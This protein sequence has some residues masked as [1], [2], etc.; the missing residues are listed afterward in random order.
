MVWYRVSCVSDIA[1]YFIC[2]GLMRKRCQLINVDLDVEGF[3]SPSGTLPPKNIHCT[4]PPPTYANPYLNAGSSGSSETGKC[5]ITGG[6]LFM[7]VKA[8]PYI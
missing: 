1:I 4:P 6:R 7:S 8:I 5:Q 3:H 2:I